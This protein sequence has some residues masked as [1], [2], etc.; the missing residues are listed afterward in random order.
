M[1]VILRT[2]LNWIV[3]KLDALQLP[4]RDCRQRVP[5]EEYLYPYCYKC[6][7]RYENAEIQCADCGKFFKGKDI[8]TYSHLN[9]RSYCIKCQAGRGL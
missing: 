7:R 4:C 6:R 3:K 5:E 1:S 9:F 2:V 8:E